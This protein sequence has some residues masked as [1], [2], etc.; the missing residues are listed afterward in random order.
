[1]N[2]L[3]PAL[4]APPRSEVTAPAD[5]PVLP[6]RYLPPGQLIAS[7]EPLVVTTILG[8]CVSLC[9]WDASA[10]VGGIN[11]YL[12]PVGVGAE[13]QQ[14]RYGDYANEHLL[15]QVLDLGARVSRLKAKI[16]GG[17][18]VLVAFRKGSDFADRN[19][20][21]AMEFLRDRGISL[22]SNDVGGNR[23]R[24]LRFHTADG[25]ALIRYV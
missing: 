22:V 5:A 18:C 10:G 6:T 1:M 13:S 17:A 20:R 7:A 11:H 23:G 8:S 2:V 14:E 25:T 24:K 9:L 16:F 15:R 19:A 21:T 4:M 12:L 3:E